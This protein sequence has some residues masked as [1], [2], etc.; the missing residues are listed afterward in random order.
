MT[1]KIII[2]DRESAVIPFFT[3]YDDIN[4]EVKRLQIGDYAIQYNDVILFII[5]RKTWKDLAASIKDGRK[6]NINKLIYLR[7][8]CACKI[9]YLIEGKYRYSQSTLIGGI[10]FKNLQAH[11]DHLMMRD[12]VYMIYSASAENTEQRLIEFTRNYMTL[13]IPAN[14]STDIS[15]GGKSLLTEVIP[16]TDLDIIYQMWET[17]PNITSKT[18]SIL[19]ANNIRISDLILGKVKKEN[20]STLTYPNGT[21]IG[22]RAEKILKI[23]Y[24]NSENINVYVNI[25][26]AIP[27]ITK[28]TAKI[29]FEKISIDDLLLE[30]I[31]IE[32]L[33]EI[34]K[35]EKSKLGKKAAENIYKFLIKQ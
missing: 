15:S 11:I 30:K 3:E 17:I 34:K 32:S 2:D 33:S 5:E 26:S 35:S 25:L 14:P 4:I 9:I 16:K 31:S 13:N 7:D 23:V 1:Y 10:P 29:I 21:I 22:K 8:N 18:A 27:L 24:T 19:I 20:I 6:E 12:N 28:K